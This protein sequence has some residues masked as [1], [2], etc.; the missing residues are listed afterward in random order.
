MG[1]IVEG[2]GGRQDESDTSFLIFF[3]S[4]VQDAPSSQDIVAV[5]VLVLASAPSFLDQA[6]V[7]S[8]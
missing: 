1:D 7:V 4:I 6:D 2:C 3:E 8:K 5:R